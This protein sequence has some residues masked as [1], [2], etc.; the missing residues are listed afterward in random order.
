LG[1]RISP[2]VFEGGSI[3]AEGRGGFLPLK[4]KLNF[5]L[6]CCLSTHN[7]LAEIKNAERLIPIFLGCLIEE[8]LVALGGG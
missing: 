1:L 8:M 4:L 7:Q 3:F 2:G 6:L 5:Y